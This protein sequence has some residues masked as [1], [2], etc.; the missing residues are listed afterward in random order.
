MAR[1]TVLTE[2]DRRVLL[3]RSVAERTWLARMPVTRKVALF[4]VVA[5][6]V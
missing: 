2:T 6:G 1:R 3:A 4:A 5:F